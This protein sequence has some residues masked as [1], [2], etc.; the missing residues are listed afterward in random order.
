NLELFEEM[1]NG[2]FAEGSKTLRA[3]FDMSSGN[4]NLRDP[5]LYRIKFS[6]HP[7]TGD[8]GCIYPMYTFAHPLEDA[9]E[10]ITHSL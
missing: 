7:K 4:I 1:K 9:I 2:K 3:K 10:K 6:H 5:A 8:K